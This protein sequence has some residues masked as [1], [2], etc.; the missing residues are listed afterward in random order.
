MC[1]FCKFALK[2]LDSSCN[3][4]A[5]SLIS[6]SLS[7][8]RC[9]RSLTRSANFSLSSKFLSLFN[10]RR[11]L[12][13]SVVAKIYASFCLILMF[14]SLFNFERFRVCA[15]Q[16]LTSSECFWS[17]C[18]SSAFD[19]SYLQDVINYWFI[20]TSHIENSYLANAESCL[21]CKDLNKR[22][23]VVNS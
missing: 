21:L 22:F 2:V 19:P 14:N 6:L 12:F 8:N 3:L 17:S 10:C 13:W 7:S 16:V 15:C 9:S 4:L 1:S 11:C 18:G 20:I 5:N 23:S